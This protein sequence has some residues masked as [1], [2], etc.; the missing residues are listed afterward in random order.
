[1]KLAVLL[2]LMGA[3]A[4]VAAVLIRVR[5]GRR[6]QAVGRLLDAADALETRLRTARAELEAVTGDNPTREAMQEMLRQR[7]WLQ[8]HGDGASLD[9][10]ESVR[11]SLEEARERIDQQLTRIR[12]ARAPLV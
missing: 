8:Q 2:L 7:L 11:R 6:R 12:D 5:G 3:A 10:I 4:L 9:Q 1:M